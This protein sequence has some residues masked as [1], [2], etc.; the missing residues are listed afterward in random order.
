MLLRVAVRSGVSDAALTVE[1]AEGEGSLVGDGEIV[2]GGGL[3][4]VS[5][6]GTIR[7][8]S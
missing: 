7:S 6:T 2:P 1:V 4:G 5:G 8:K 3:L